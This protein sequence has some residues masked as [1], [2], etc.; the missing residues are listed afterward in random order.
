ML[1]FPPGLWLHIFSFVEGYKT[2][3]DIILTSTSH[4]FNALGQQELVRNMS[5]NPQRHRLKELNAC[6]LHSPSQAQAN[7]AGMSIFP[8]L[9]ELTI[10]N[11]HI[12]E[13]IHA[14][15][16]HL[17]NVYRLRLQWCTT[18]ASSGAQSNL[19]PAHR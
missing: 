17:P 4:Q 15:L 7:V 8:K 19:S 10:F 2:F 13:E 3:K 1:T 14:V 6:L 16:A 12:T 9:G 5:T 18:C 11:A